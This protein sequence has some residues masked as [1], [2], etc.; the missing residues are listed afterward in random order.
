[1]DAGLFF[2]SMI[3]HWDFI[4]GRNPSQERNG[5]TVYNKI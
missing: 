1:M 5:L 2:M 4:F 3:A